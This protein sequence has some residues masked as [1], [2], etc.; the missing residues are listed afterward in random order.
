MNSDDKHFGVLYFLDKNPTFRSML[1]IS[2]QSLKRF[3]PDWPVEVMESPTFTIPLWK[4]IYRAASFWKWQERRAR[5]NQDWRVIF[6]KSTGMIDTPFENTLYLDVDTVLVKPFDDLIERAMECD[7]MSTPLGWKNYNGFDEWQPKT[8]PMVMA[9]VVFYNKKFTEVYRDY[10]KK[11]SVGVGKYFAGDQY[12]FSMACYMEEKNLNICYE[13]SLQIDAMN[14][15]EHLG[16]QNYPKKYGVLDLT[17]EGLQ[18]F[19][20]FHYNG[21]HKKEYLSQIKDIWGLPLDE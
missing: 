19:Y 3:H 5:A 2:I 9:G 8:Y 6:A 14:I 20:I 13:P 7:V 11:L 15:A 16:S 10:I 18:K 12:M 21:P 4:K 1:K 17:Y